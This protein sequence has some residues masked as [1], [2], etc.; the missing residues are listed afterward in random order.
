VVAGNPY[1]FDL[2]KAPQHE[3]ARALIWNDGPLVGI[4]QETSELM[5]CTRDDDILYGSGKDVGC[6]S[7]GLGTQSFDATNS[8]VSVTVFGWGQTVTKYYRFTSAFQLE[9]KM[10]ECG[11]LAFVVPPPAKKVLKTS[12]YD[13]ALNAFSATSVCAKDAGFC[14]QSDAGYAASEDCDGDGV[15]DHWCYIPGTYEGFISSRHSCVVQEKPCRR[16]V[17]PGRTFGCQRPLGWCMHGETY[18]RDVDCDGDGH[19]DHECEKAGH[20]GFISSKLDCIDT[21]EQGSTGRKCDPRPALL[22]QDASITYKL[23]RDS[24]DCV[25]HS[26]SQCFKSHA[27]WPKENYQ[28][29]SKCQ[30]HVEAAN[31]ILPAADDCGKATQTDKQLW[32]ETVYEEIERP[33]FTT[34]GTSYGDKF[35][36]GSVL[37]HSIQEGD[38]V[39]E[40]DSQVYDGSKFEFVADGSVE[41]EGWL[42][43]LREKS[44]ITKTTTYKASCTEIGDDIWSKFGNVD[45]AGTYVSIECDMVKCNKA[46]VDSV[47]N[48]GNLFVRTTNLCDA[49]WQVQRDDKFEVQFYDPSLTKGVAGALQQQNE[50]TFLV[51]T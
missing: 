13:S 40:L 38:T 37:M 9:G 7:W 44:K 8:A 15:L 19:F 43:C 32:L 42:V 20:S 23:V 11:V 31:H 2:L 16:S 39:L 49:G 24:G 26:G 18:K 5:S 4:V 33:V 10:N 6:I 14:T 46:K 1:K 25:P 28:P 21:W 51:S 41:K 22:D 36:V 12:N 47:K 27:S 3:L 48:N 29:N 34:L 30:F 35:S 17:L 50:A 45:Q